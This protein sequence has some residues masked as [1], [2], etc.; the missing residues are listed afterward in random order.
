MM[1]K[2]VLIFLL[3]PILSYSQIRFGLR[4]SLQNSNVSKI[5]KESSSRIA[6][7]VGVL[8]QIQLDDYNRFFIQP[9]I[10]YSLQG[11]KDKVKLS[12]NTTKAKFY[13]N[14]IN[15]PV[16]F[17]AY[18]SESESEFFTE[19]GPQ[20][21]LLISQKDK[22]LEKKRYGSNPKN[23]DASISIGLGYSII[24]KSEFFIRYNYGFMDIY[25]KLH[26]QQNTSV[27][28]FGFAY[29]FD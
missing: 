24:R 9:E 11:E 25:D 18:F 5:H 19:I 1:K 13:Q 23:F 28:S 20:L 8:A 27:V 26:E 6:G 4:G 22:E 17:R 3:I 10:S 29:I 7:S 15:I 12:G 2:S 14:Y 16:Y 21:G